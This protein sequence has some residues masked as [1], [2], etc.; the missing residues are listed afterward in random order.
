MTFAA[1]PAEKPTSGSNTDYWAKRTVQR[2]RTCTVRLTDI[3]LMHCD[4]IAETGLAGDFDIY[5]R[6]TIVGNT[7]QGHRMDSQGRFDT[8]VAW[9]LTRI[10]SGFVRV[11][12]STTQ[13]CTPDFAGPHNAVEKAPHVRVQIGTQTVETDDNGSAE[14]EVPA[15]SYDVFASLP[16]ATFGYVNQTGQRIF[17]NPEKRGNMVTLSGSAAALEVRMLNCG[18]NRLRMA[19]ARVTR[20]G[21]SMTVSRNGREA[22]AFVGMQLRDGDDVNIG[23]GGRLEW[24]EGGGVIDFDYETFITIGSTEPKSRVNPN[25]AN[26]FG[27]RIHHGFGAFMLPPAEKKKSRF[28]ASTGTVVT[29]VKGT[30]FGLGYDERTRVST[31]R[32]ERGEVEVTPTNHSL[33]S[34]A[35]HAGQEVQV[36]ATRTFAITPL[37]RRYAKSVHETPTSPSG[38]A[39]A[40]AN[41]AAA[42]PPPQAPPPP[43]PLPQQLPQQLPQRLAAGPNPPSDLRPNTGYAQ[44][45]PAVP[46]GNVTFRWRIASPIDARDS[47]VTSFLDIWYWDLNARTWRQLYAGYTEQR[48]ASTVETS[49][50]LSLAPRTGYAWRVFTIDLTARTSSAPSS[51]AAFHT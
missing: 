28:G 19:R 5:Y 49:Y 14:V 43:A 24:L 30:V 47:A 15:G 45:D 8:N 35:L 46:G 26:F 50:T 31:V 36:S 21:Q 10:G 16:D 44:N 17:Y 48:T 33:H 40:R 38:N 2:V 34:F 6:G 12:V 32:V 22:S 7:V 41:S 3:V 25:V 1:R 13:S 18:E 23:E 39:L 9:T 27:I 20:I 42:A 4:P 29:S 37:S 51:W 11:R